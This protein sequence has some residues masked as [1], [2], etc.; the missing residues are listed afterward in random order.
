[1]R[2]CAPMRREITNGSNREDQRRRRYGARLLIALRSANRCCMLHPQKT[3]IV[4]CKDANR[5]GDFPNQSLD[6]LG[7]SFRARKTLWRGYMHAHGFLPAARPKALTSISRVIRRWALHHHSDKSLQDLAKT[8]NPYIEGGSTTTATSI[9]RS[10]TRPSRGSM[11]MSSAGRAG[12]SSGCVTRPKG[13]E[14]G[15]RGFAVPIQLSSLT[16]SYVMATAEHREPYES[17]GSR[18]VLGARGGEISP[19]NSTKPASLLIKRKSASARI[20]H[21]LYHS[22]T[23][24]A[25]PS[26]VRGNDTPSARAVLR[27]MNN[28]TF[29]ACWTG[30]SAGLAP[31]RIRPVWIP[32]WWPQSVI[33]PP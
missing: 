5:R 27:L 19:R 28:S 8:Y 6:F 3:K 18:T 30:R 22:I 24:S 13:R 15:L 10:C 11:S 33:L 12:S 17:R 9:G 7:F 4:Y 20:G 26:N 23:S 31:A 21:K 16:G 2:T 1:V 14:A 32:P 29:V 25:R